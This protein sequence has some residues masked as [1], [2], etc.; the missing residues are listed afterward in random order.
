MSADTRQCEECKWQPLGGDGW[1]Y[2]FR[3][4]PHGECRQRRVPGTTSLTA[5]PFAVLL[6][7]RAILDE[8]RERM[9][10]EKKT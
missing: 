6:A 10:E 4:A 8:A 5:R 2:L 7:A 3:D 1:C 9:K